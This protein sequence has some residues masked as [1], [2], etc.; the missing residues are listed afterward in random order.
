[1]YSCLRKIDTN[2]QQKHFK[3]GM[4]EYVADAYVVCK[5]IV[6][7]F[8]MY[9][10]VVDHHLSCADDFDIIIGIEIIGFRLPCVR[11]RVRV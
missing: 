3:A 8:A 11:L 9:P 7:L 5:I 1:M 10:V 6:N 2:L 4:Y